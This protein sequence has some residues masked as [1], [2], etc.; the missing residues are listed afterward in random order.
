MNITADDCRN[1]V[2]HAEAVHHGRTWTLWYNAAGVQIHAALDPANI[3]EDVYR[4][5]VRASGLCLGCEAAGD[6]PGPD[7]DSPWCI[8]TAPKQ[9]VGH[10]DHAR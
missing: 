4:E 9:E 5:A 7:G 8:I 10:D 3:S 6:C 1:L 2:R